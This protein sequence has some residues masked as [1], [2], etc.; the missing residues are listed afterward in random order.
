MQPLLCKWRS[1]PPEDLPKV[2]V[3]FYDTS[4]SKESFELPPFLSKAAVKVGRW[5]FPEHAKAI[6]VMVPDMRVQHLAMVRRPGICNNTCSFIAWAILEYID[7]WDVHPAH[8]SDLNATPQK[9]LC[10]DKFEE[11]GTR[12]KLPS[13]THLSCDFL[14]QRPHLANTYKD[15][16]LETKISPGL[17]MHH[18]MCVTCQSKEMASKCLNIKSI[19]ICYALSDH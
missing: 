11:S 2:F 1:S 4:I 7:G 19:Q 16:R 13:E 10:I 6:W 12:K 18:L 8:W 9:Y 3:P 15:R 17:A 14:Q 5:C